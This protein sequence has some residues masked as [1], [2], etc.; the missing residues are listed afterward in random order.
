MSEKGNKKA[1]LKAEGFH[2][3]GSV[4]FVIVMA[5]TTLE[6]ESFSSMPEQRVKRR[7]I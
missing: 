6:A 1:K 7:L 4:T 5:W 2:V 3:N